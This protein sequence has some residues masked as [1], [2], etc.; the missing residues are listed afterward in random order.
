MLQPQCVPAMGQ[1]LSYRACCF[2]LAVS[3]WPWNLMYKWV[4]GCDITNGICDLGLSLWNLGS[5]NE[6][7]YV[8]LVFL[9]PSYF[10]L[11]DGLHLCPLCLKHIISF[12]SVAEL[13]HCALEP[14][15]LFPVMLMDT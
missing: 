14:Y 5:T 4:G 13:L 6:R 1:V 3:L 7:N 9:D 15:I 11:C 2:M 12:F 10:T 8:T